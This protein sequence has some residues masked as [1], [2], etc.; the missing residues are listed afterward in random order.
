LKIKGGENKMIRRVDS[1]NLFSENPTELYKFYKDTVGVEFTLEAE[2]GEGEDMYGY[3]PKEGS[4]FYIVHHKSVKGKN[5]E[6]ERYMLNF[7]VDDI[8]KEVSRLDEAKV[9]KIQDIYHVEDY[10]FIATFQDPDGNYF[11][12]VKVR[13]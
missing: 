7:E 3:E 9:K 1:I 5:Q 12:L 8:E 13:P 2:I 4:G 6:P 11:Q 10:G